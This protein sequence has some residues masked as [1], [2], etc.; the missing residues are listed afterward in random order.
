[1]ALAVQKFREMVLQILYSTDMAGEEEAMIAFMMGTLKVTKRSV[2]S[3]QE[4]VG[5]ILARKEE[6]DQFI[7][8]AAIGYEI[9]RISR[10]EKNVL[11]LGIFEMLFEKEIPEKVALAEAIRLTRKFGTKESAQF[12]NAVL[13]AI[14]K[15]RPISQ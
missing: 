3:A 15:K 4:K 10:V 5:K 9:D 2:L 13:D 14:Y 8:G 11:R 6:L 12:V 7:A 1:M